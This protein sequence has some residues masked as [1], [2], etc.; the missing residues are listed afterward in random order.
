MANYGGTYN[1][2][3]GGGMGAIPKPWYELGQPADPQQAALDEYLSASR[4]RI[5]QI[6]SDPTDRL[7]MDRLQQMLKPDAATQQAMA[8]FQQYSNPAATKHALFTQG[9]D[10]ATAAGAARWGQQAEGLALRGLDPKD[11]SYQAAQSQNMMQ[12]QQDIQRARLNATLG[13]QQQS[14]AAAGRLASTAGAQNAQQQAA[15]AAMQAQSNRIQGDKLKAGS[16][17]D[18]ATF[19]AAQN[20]KPAAQQTIYTSGGSRPTSDPAWWDEAFGSGRVGVNVPRSGIPGQFKG[21]LPGQ[22]K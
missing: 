14:M 7:I 18:Y 5:N 1:M 16:A 11:G 9:A 22:F 6:G 10:Q 21:S 12:R 20:K 3:G 4:N 15:L 13:A 17:L 19:M 8:T 2:G